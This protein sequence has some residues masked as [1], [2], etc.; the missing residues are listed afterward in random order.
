MQKAH[1]MHPKNLLSLLRSS[2]NLFR[3]ISGA[4]TCDSSVNTSFVSINSTAP[5]D[6]LKFII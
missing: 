5:R 1:K 4:L 3:P 2:S 6:K